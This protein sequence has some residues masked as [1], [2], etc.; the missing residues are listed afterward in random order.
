MSNYILS[1]FTD[2]N[3]PNYINEFS[4]AILEK[5]DVHRKN[6]HLSAVILSSRLI[7]YVAVEDFAAFLANKFPEYSISIINK[8]TILFTEI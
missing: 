2:Y 3:N 4:E 5:I 1:V 8:F 6:S 7:P